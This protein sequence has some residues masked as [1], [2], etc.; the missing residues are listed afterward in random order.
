MNTSLPFRI[1]KTNIYLAI[2][3]CFLLFNCYTL[4][5]DT[6]KTI[7]IFKIRQRHPYVFFGD[8]FRGIESF[9]GNAP[10]LG[11]YTDKN[12]E[13]D[14]RAA[15]KFAQAQNVLAPSILDLN[16]TKHEFIIFDCSSP[17]VAMAKI[18][19]IGAKPLKANPYGIILAR[20]ADQSLTV[21]GD[22][23]VTFDKTIQKQR[24]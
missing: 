8:Q 10:F 14:P 17:A 1:S 13:L 7:K 16:N 23:Q 15:M 2:A 9:T 20:N 4:A 21:Q 22:N 5:A 18:Q 3:G 12:I 6:L 24:P 19:E 11:Y